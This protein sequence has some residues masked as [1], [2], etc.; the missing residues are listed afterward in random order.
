MFSGSNNLLELITTSLDERPS[1]ISKWPPCKVNIFPISWL[2]SDLGGQYWC[3]N[4]FWVELW[5]EGYN[6]FTRWACHLGFQNGRLVKRIFAN[7]LA[8]K[9]LRRSISV[10]KY[11]PWVEEC[12]IAR[13]NFTAILDFKMATIW[14]RNPRWLLF[15]QQIQEDYKTVNILVSPNE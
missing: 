6:N 9:R 10:S 2:S 15:G 7:I 1:W 13:Y 14:H 3:Q 4:V 11:A 8:F 5:F 12:V